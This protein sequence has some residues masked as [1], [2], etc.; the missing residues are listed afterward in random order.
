VSSGGLLVVIQVPADQASQDRV[1]ALLAQAAA[2]DG[3]SACSG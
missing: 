3:E 2:R 1:A